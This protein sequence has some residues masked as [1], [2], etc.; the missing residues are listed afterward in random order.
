MLIA[1][2]H[3]EFSK[4]K[5]VLLHGPGP[6]V[7]NM[8][9]ATAER[10]LYSDILNLPIAQLE[11][12]QFRGVLK[13]VSEVFEVKP[14]LC[15]ILEKD[16]TR[17]ELLVQLEK[18]SVCPGLSEELSGLS[19]SRLT[20]VLIEGILL[21]QNS[22]TNF[23]Q[24]NKYSINPLH[25]MFFM[26]DASFCIGNTIFISSMARSVRKPETIIL[27]AVY[28]HL[29]DN[30]S[31]LVYLNKLAGSK[32]SIEGGDILVVSPE[33]LIIG[34]GSRTTPEAVDYLIGQVSAIQPLNYVI[35]QE[36]PLEPESFIH[37]DMVFTL[38]SESECMVYK[39]L[40]E[41]EWHY[42]TI[43]MKIENGVVRKISYVENIME[44]LKKCRFGFEPVFCGNGDP[45]S[46][47]REQWHSGANFFAFSP[48]HIIGYARNM[49]TTNALNK[50]GY[51]IIKA[52]DVIS[53]TA[54]PANYKKCL[55]TI[56]GSELA[57]GGG[58][59]RCMTMPLL[60]D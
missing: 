19:V 37:L 20:N 52:N 24:Q 17:S 38:L 60:R 57:R 1:G 33:V 41:S 32:F 21:P 26:R 7:E 49:H 28:R 39:P 3:S 5:T 18:F 43:L 51:E 16:E 58:G 9:P 11:Y 6:E 25:N 2:I 56:E 59:P 40:L 45:M 46:Q 30:N 34:I 42:H 36:L 50:I 8:T 12:A 44:G 29:L 35:V 10:A 4:L 27:E 15:S 47:E 14:M 22:L 13:K 53:G 55:V 31:R 23:L 48:G 54:S